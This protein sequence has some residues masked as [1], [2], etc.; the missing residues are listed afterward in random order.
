MERS[1]QHYLRIDNSGMGMGQVTTWARSAQSQSALD[2]SLAPLRCGDIRY[3]ALTKNR[4]DRHLL[5]TDFHLDP[6]KIRLLDKLPIA[7]T[8]ERG[9]KSVGVGKPCS[10]S[11]MRHEYGQGFPVPITNQAVYR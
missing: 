9:R 10:G 2:L 11:L 5:T 6:I 8:P 4:A 3:N 1:H 7:R